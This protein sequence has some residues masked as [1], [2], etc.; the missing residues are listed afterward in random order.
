VTK[1]LKQLDRY[2]P[3]KFN[4]PYTL[5]LKLKTETRVYDGSFYPGVKRTG[6]WE[7]TFN[8]DDI[9]EIV[10]AFVWMLK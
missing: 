2:K 3:Y 7:L 6:D 4:A 9:M 10:K 5:V 8:S 1:A